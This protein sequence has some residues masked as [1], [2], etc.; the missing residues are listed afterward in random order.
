MHKN[1]V[2]PPPVIVAIM[3]GLMWLCEKNL[4]QMVFLKFDFSW[5]KPLATGLL[6]SGVVLMLFAAGTFFAVKTTINPLRPARASSLVTCGVFRFSRNP[7]YLGDLLVLAAFA[8]WLGN[9]L[10]FGF[11]VLF[12]RIISRFQIEPEER[13]L[14]ELF[15][16]A[17]LDYCAKVRRWC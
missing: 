8:L 5:Q 17:Y 13:A 14:T 16:Q 15:G 4:T 6:V 9:F 2:L 12:I 3:A 1:P 7:I 10:N 11:L